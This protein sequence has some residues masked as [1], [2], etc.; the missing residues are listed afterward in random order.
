MKTIFF[1]AALTLGMVSNA[2]AAD[3]VFNPKSLH[4]KL[5]VKR[6]VVSA[7]ADKL[8]A[9]QIELRGYL[10]PNLQ[11]QWEYYADVLNQSKRMKIAPNTFE[12]VF[13]RMHPGGE[14]LLDTRA[15][16]GELDIE[17]SGRSRYQIKNAFPYCCST[18]SY[19]MR[20]RERG[21]NRI[22]AKTSIPQH[23]LRMVR[24]TELKLVD[25]GATITARVKAPP[26][27]TQSASTFAAVIKVTG[28][29]SG[30]TV[31]QTFDWVIPPGETLLV[32]PIRKLDRGA[33]VPSVVVYAKT[34]CAGD[35]DDQCW[36]AQASTHKW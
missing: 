24:I 27:H 36:I 11:G 22:I 25:D 20:L 3:P 4:T 5:K 16:S 15:V 23:T 14:T 18:P 1:V 13:L 33:A 34:T 32:R 31:V 28:K 2:C 8:Q 21:T 29:I 7:Q 19:E 30:K 17:G 12:L 9:Y 10:K 26:V 35:A 6:P